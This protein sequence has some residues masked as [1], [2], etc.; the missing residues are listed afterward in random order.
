MKVAIVTKQHSWANDGSFPITSLSVTAPTPGLA[1]CQTG[2]ESPGHRAGVRG[3]S[4][5][6]LPSASM[7]RLPPS[8]PWVRVGPSESFCPARCRPRGT[9]RV[10]GEGVPAPGG[11]PQQEQCGPPDKLELEARKQREPSKPSPQGNL[12]CFGKCLS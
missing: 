9:W 1:A 5:L 10:L 7:P 2:F 4:W 6:A 8:T 11:T 12:S 3:A